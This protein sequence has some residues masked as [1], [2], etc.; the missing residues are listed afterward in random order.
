MSNKSHIL[1]EIVHVCVCRLVPPGGRCTGPSG[2]SACGRRTGTGRGPCSPRTAA[3]SR[4]RLDPRGPESSADRGPTVWTTWEMRLFVSDS[5]RP[6][7]L[8]CFWFCFLLFG[9]L[10][11]KSGGR[12]DGGNVTQLSADDRLGDVVPPGQT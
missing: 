2:A 9:R 5:A 7:F 10:V 8:L 11:L 4:G 12:A 3:S 1:N 6:V